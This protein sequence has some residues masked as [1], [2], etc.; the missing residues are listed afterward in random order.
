MGGNDK[1]GVN[2]GWGDSIL[3]AAGPQGKKLLQK[4]AFLSPSVSSDSCKG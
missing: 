3:F 1:N 2:F 4:H